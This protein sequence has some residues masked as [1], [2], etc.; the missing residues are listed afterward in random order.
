MTLT[1]ELFRSIEESVEKFG[2][3]TDAIVR[4]IDAGTYF[5][6]AY[7]KSVDEF[8][9]SINGLKQHEDDDVRLLYVS[10]RSFI[11]DWRKGANSRS[12]RKITDAIAKMARNQARIRALLLKILDVKEVTA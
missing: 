8:Y 1:T 3:L 7:D 10:M 5:A 9:R 12:G 2:E 4:D 6:S 11:S